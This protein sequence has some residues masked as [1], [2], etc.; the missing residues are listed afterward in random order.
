MQGKKRLTEKQWKHII[1]ASQFHKAIDDCNVDLVRDT[2]LDII[3]RIKNVIDDENELYALESIEEEFAIIESTDEDVEDQL[4][5]ILD[6]L[7]DFCDL[8]NIFL[9]PQGSLSEDVVEPA[10]TDT[11]PVE[12]D[13]SLVDLGISGM[14]TSAISAEWQR[15]DEY[16][17]IIATL[18]SENAEPETIQLIRNVIDNITLSI[19]QL[20]AALQKV[21]TIEIP[22][23]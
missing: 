6:E 4:D 9:D 16:N 1:P 14:F 20:E 18:I 7:Y 10:L 13:E 23:K 8:N 17:G 12:A 15:L 11:L 3:N 22:E 5:F 19:G 21:S 2:A